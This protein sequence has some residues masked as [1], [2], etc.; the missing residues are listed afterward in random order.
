MNFNLGFSVQSFSHLN[1]LSLTSQVL[2][3]TQVLSFIKAGNYFCTMQD[4]VI[5]WKTAVKNLIQVLSS[6][7]C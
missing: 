1:W 2:W 5:I 7:F 3:T 4:D 6:S